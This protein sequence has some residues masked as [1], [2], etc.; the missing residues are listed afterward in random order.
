M[1]IKTLPGYLI[2]ETPATIR[3]ALEKTDSICTAKGDPEMTPYWKNG[4]ALN[5]KS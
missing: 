3:K 4:K 5:R 1:S 2:N